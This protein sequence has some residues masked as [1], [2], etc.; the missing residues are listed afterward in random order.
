[1]SSSDDIPRDDAGKA[2][3]S[4]PDLPY[5]E[6]AVWRSII[7]NYGERPSLDNEPAAAPPPEP[8]PARDVFDRSFLDAQAPPEP[9][10]ESWSDEGHFVPPEPP[11]LPRTTPIRRLAWS[12]LFGAPALM[13]LAVVFGWAYPEWLALLL[14]GGFVGGFVYLVATMP[15]HRGNWPGDDGAVV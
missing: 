8:A 3:P 11:P 10:P 2:V 13:L 15:R 12:G 6:D 7:E 4:E 5:D 14:V 9:Q 1:M